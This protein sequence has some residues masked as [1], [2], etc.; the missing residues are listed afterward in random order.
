MIRRAA[1]VVLALALNPAMLRAQDSV[2]TVNV[3]SADIHKG[4]STGNP[5]VGH[6]S[7]GTVL[8]VTSN[9]G[10][11]VK[12]AWPEA[13]DGAGYV[14]VTMGRIGPMSAATPAMRASTPPSATPP[15][16]PASAPRTASATPTT[17][18]PAARAT[19]PMAARRTVDVTPAS[20]TVG[21]GGLV[22]SMSTYGAS[23]RTWPNNRLGIQFGLTHDSMKNSFSDDTMTAYQF[24][25]GVV[26]GFFDHVSDYIWVRPYV[27]ST[28]SFRHQTVKPAAAG[29]TESASEN[30]MGF[31]VFAGTELMF[32]SLPRFGVSADLGYR[33]F[34]TLAEG[35]DPS[36]LSFTIA[37]HWYVK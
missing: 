27:G 11:W 10:S 16:A 37:G 18:A 14:H 20:H 7:R 23:A 5:V 34:P 21:V 30:G 13:P 4:P 1:V 26:Y 17:A 8:T 12:V 31:R 33:R 29:A 24:E 36:P 19:Q 6:A 32:A 9:L 15:P 28:V 25:P 2:F 35:F 22:G 3:A